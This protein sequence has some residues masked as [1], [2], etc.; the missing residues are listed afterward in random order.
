MKKMKVCENIIYV[1][2]FILLLYRLYLKCIY[3]LPSFDGAMNL[4]VPMQLIRSGKYMTTYNGGVVFDPK[5]QTRLP[6]LGPIYLLWKIF[7]ISSEIALLVNAIY[8]CL[9][10]IITWK[11]LEKLSVNKVIRYGCAVSILFIPKFNEYSM[12]IYGEIPTLFFVLSSIYALMISEEKNNNRIFYILSGGLYSLAIL[13]KTVALIAIPSFFVIMLIRYISKK[14]SIKNIVYWISSV[15]TPLCFFEVYKISQLGFSKYINDL[16]IEFDAILKQAGVRSGYSDT[17]NIFEKVWI[18]ITL[19]CDYF[20]FQNNL[21]LIILLTFVF[22]IW[23]VTVRKN[24]KTGYFNI[25]FLLMFSYFGWWIV[26]TPTEK[27]WA[28]RVIIGVILLC[29]TLAYIIQILYNKFQSKIYMIEVIAVAIIC[30]IYVNKSI[31]DI[32]NIDTEYKKEVISISNSIREISLNEDAK[33]YGIGWWQA[34][35]LSF[36]SG[37][38]FFDANEEEVVE[39]NYFVVDKYFEMLN[40]KDVDYIVQIY[41][42]T[43]VKSEGHNTI[44]KIGQIQPLTL[45]TRKLSLYIKKI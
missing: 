25:A 27:A 11:I 40:P 30:I 5:I 43:P 2:S 32:R 21:V 3:G 35:V 37:V 42:L 31:L 24:K 17:N 20:H 23:L 8:I 38:D 44:Y 15:I 45:D 19:F 26:I 29:I 12:G 9:L 14:L 22:A 34:P 18:H 16:G 6:V 41:N 36:F 7:G 1:V 28:R 4:Q 39:N 10:I 33:F 13:C